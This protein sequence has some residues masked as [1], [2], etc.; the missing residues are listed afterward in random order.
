MKFIIGRLYQYWKNS[1]EKNGIA[2]CDT[3]FNWLSI[4]A[5]ESIIRYAVD[6]RNDLINSFGIVGNIKTRSRSG[7][8]V[9]PLIRHWYVI[10]AGFLSRFFSTDRDLSSRRI[11][12]RLPGDLKSIA[13]RTYIGRFSGNRSILRFHT[14]RSRKFERFFAVRRTKKNNSHRQVRIRS[15]FESKVFFNTI[16]SIKFQSFPRVNIVISQK[17]AEQTE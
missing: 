13:N 6:I 9:R 2:C 5:P 17:L 11:R 8:P 14:I 10:V 12:I 1:I 3:H 4:A 15:S 16:Q 7:E